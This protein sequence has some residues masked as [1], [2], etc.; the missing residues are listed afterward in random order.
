M[1]QFCDLKPMAEEQPE[2]QSIF[3][4]IAD[5]VQAILRL[6]QDDGGYIQV[7]C[8]VRGID[9]PRL[10][11]FFP[12]SRLPKK[13]D[14]SRPCLLSVNNKSDDEPPLIMSV[15]I[16]DRT[17]PRTLEVM[18]QRRIDPAT[19][20]AFFR[21]TISL[22]IV[23]SPLNYDEGEETW[24]L[25]GRTLDISGSGTLA[26]FPADCPENEHIAIEI[27]LDTTADKTVHCSG[28]VVFKR[29][30]RGGRFQ[31]A[32]HFDDIEQK[33]QSALVATCLNEQRRQ[34]RE[35]IRTE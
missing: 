27:A 25:S 10:T 24:S 19:L 13:L 34:L 26:F 1:P 22:P 21:V 12:P 30:L 15:L 31:I 18:V 32:L 8:Q 28:H 2:L 9:P 6:E 7:N 16:S 35:H 4:A 29:R 11:L 17:D 14:M 3:A 20:R 23:L 5:D 33:A